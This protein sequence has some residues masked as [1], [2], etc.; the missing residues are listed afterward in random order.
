MP[1]VLANHAYRKAGALALAAL[2]CSAALPASAQDSGAAPSARTSRPV[3]EPATGTDQ[4]A[5]EATAA[6]ETPE[7]SVGEAEPQPSQSPET[8]GEA[9]A[10]PAPAADEPGAA[11]SDAD[12]QASEEELAPLPIPAEDT[13]TENV[14]RE[15]H[16]A[17]STICDQPPG[18][19]VEQCALMQNVIAEDRPEIGLSIAVLKTADREA[20]LLRILS[21]LGVFLPSGMDMF[22]DGVNIGK[23]YFTRCYLDGCYVEIDIDEDLMKIM[24]AGR[25]AV[26][27]L[28]FSVDQD[29]IGIPVDLTG[30][31]EGFDNLP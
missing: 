4:A 27:T 12:A 8:E 7:A 19:S 11:T 5:P 6:E 26:F 10:T 31:V 3:E 28:T 1:V 16:G 22:V 15:N 2:L 30:F 20:T 21:P 14:V 9:G 17:W 25:E 18:S 24:R 29:T 13:V 23:G